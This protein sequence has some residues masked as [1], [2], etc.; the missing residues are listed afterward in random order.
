MRKIIVVSA[1]NLIEGGPLTVL[2]KCLGYLSAN[3]SDEYEIIALVNRKELLPFENIK[4]L[5]FPKSKKSWL[6]RL[7]YEYYY[8]DKLAKR[9]NPF[10][11]LSLHD[12][13]PKVTAERRAVYCHNASPF[14]R[15]S[16]H[17]FQL[18]PKFF[19]FTLFYK[20][21]YSINIHRNMFVIVQQ[22]WMRK[23][24]ANRFELQN[25]IVSRPESNDNFNVISLTKPDLFTFIYPA[26]PRPFKNFEVICSAAEQLYLKGVQDFKII[27]TINGSESR[28]SHLIYNKF[29]HV[30]VLSFTG[31]QSRNK[32]LEYYSISDCLIFP[33]KLETWGL[34]ISE[35][36]KHDKPIL[37]ANLPYAHE[38][39]GDYNKVKFFSPDN[40]R[41]LADAMEALMR[42]DLTF[43]ATNAGN[44]EPP[45]AENWE[46][47][48][49]ILLSV[50]PPAVSL[51]SN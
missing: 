46:Q 37:L 16:F 24:F 44:I 7:Y 26:F 12:I 11:W 43:D 40:V 21:L 49:D 50:Q 18:E 33:S 41:E 27:L 4:Y 51:T 9:L 38:T 48:F 45:Y 5:E 30:P 35:F 47:L 28:Y 36:K 8:F 17:T 15:S 3:L 1:V 39:V 32:I 6:N 25:I 14:Y 34:P 10:L 20:Y 42:G 2:Q 13:T 31:L 29:K 22:D 19:L 23:E